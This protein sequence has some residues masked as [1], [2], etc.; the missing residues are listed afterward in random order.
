MKR[1]ELCTGSVSGRSAADDQGPRSLTPEKDASLIVRLEAIPDFVAWGN[2]GC[3][4]VGSA[5]TLGS[6]SI[7]AWNNP[8]LSG[9]VA[10]EQAE[11]S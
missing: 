7:S 11:D 3:P 5:T 6:S 1:I 2:F 10:R 8:S 9:P 4:K